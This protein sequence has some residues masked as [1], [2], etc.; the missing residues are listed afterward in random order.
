MRKTRHDTSKN[1]QIPERNSEDAK[2]ILRRF[3]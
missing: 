3:G 1:P 2:D